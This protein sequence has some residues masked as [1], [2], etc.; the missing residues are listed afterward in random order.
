MM[1]W[2]KRFASYLSAHNISRPAAAAMFEATASQVH[3]WLHGSTPHPSKR[4]LIE[5]RTKGEVPADPD[6]PRL[7]RPG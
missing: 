6:V 7:S 3:Y 4:K 2:S 5:R 1:T